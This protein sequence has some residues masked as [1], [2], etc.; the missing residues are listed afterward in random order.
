MNDTNNQ[1]ASSSSTDELVKKLAETQEDPHNHHEYP[2]MVNQHRSTVIYT[3]CPD[4]ALDIA[5]EID[6]WETLDYSVELMPP[7]ADEENDN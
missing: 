3:C 7:S 2:F 1:S 5:R 4:T 6:M